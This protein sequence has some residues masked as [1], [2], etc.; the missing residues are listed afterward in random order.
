MKDWTTYE[1]L[2]DL[3]IVGP[4]DLEIV[5]HDF[6]PARVEVEEPT[7]T[8]SLAQRTWRYKL[9]KGIFL[10]LISTMERNDTRSAMHCLHIGSFVRWEVPEEF[11]KKLHSLAS[12]E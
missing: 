7:L 6:S 5:L 10:E 9:E 3:I 1:E 12:Q 2:G 11:A 8:G 4:G